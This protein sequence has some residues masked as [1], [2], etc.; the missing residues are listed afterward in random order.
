VDSWRADV[1]PESL[2]G[3]NNDDDIVACTLL[4]GEACRERKN[5]ACLFALREVLAFRFP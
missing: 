2:L 1:R 4:G 5:S 3:D